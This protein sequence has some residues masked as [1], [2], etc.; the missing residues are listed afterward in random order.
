MVKKETKCSVDKIENP[1]TKNCVNKTG[2]I[3]K[4][5]VKQCSTDKILNLETN[6]CVKS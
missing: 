6:R 3:G 2:R 4:T 1:K 5:L